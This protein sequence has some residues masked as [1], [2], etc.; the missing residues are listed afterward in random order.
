M[1]CM[2]QPAHSYSTVSMGWDGMGWVGMG[3]GCPSYSI[4]FPTGS[5]QAWFAGGWGWLGERLEEAS[6]HGLAR[7]FV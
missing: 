3:W 2:T 1:G 5:S 6:G 4:P 7:P